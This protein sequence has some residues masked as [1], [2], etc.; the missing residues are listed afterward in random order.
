[1]SVKVGIPVSSVAL[2][3]VNWAQHGAKRLVRFKEIGKGTDRDNI[4]TGELSRPVTDRSYWEGR[5]VLC[6]L[7]LAQ[8]GGESLTFVDAVTAVSRKKRIVS[9]AL[10]GRDGTVKEYINSEDW[11]IN[12]V[13]GIQSEANGEIADEWPGNELRRLRKLLEAKET[14]NVHSEFLDV[15]N[16]G[17]IVIKSYSATQM[18]EAN[19]Q[20]VEISAES[21]EEYEIFSKE[22]EQPKT[23]TEQ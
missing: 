5:Y 3:A 12:I 13:L 10:T 4:T 15:F 1:M 19:Y 2:S 8:E 6:E 21:D 18:T 11:Q 7:T 22:Y 23:D 9:T 20:A 16:I 17:R 14:L